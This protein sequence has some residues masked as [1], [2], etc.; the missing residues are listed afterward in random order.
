MS[1]NKPVLY[2]TLKAEFMHR[3]SVFAVTQ[4]G[5]HQIYGRNENN[6]SSHCAKRDLYGKF[7]TKEAAEAAIDQYMNIKDKHRPDI[8]A[9][10]LAYRK[11]TEAEAKELDKYLNQI[12][13]LCLSGS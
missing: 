5:L 6:Q 8:E 1:R 9:A 13:D 4:V 12:G 10:A 11:T 7:D 2:W 3:C